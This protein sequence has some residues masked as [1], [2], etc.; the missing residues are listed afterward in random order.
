MVLFFIV[1][2]MK[3]MYVM[4]CVLRSVCVYECV[5]GG[6]GALRGLFKQFLLLTSYWFRSDKFND[7]MFF[8]SENKFIV[9]CTQKTKNGLNEN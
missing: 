3:F 7:A 4:Q 9:L 8:F 5:M 6:G 1:K 2:C